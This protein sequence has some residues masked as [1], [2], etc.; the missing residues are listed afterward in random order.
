MKTYKITYKTKEGCTITIED[1]IFESH[2]KSYL[3]LISRGVINF[4]V[5]VI[6]E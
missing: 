4:T 1:F 2:M 5:Q 3:D 6:K